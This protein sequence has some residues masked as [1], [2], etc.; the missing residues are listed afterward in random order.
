MAMLIEAY[1]AEG[2]IALGDRYSFSYL[3]DLIGQ[4]AEMRKSDEDRE[5]EVLDEKEQ[6]FFEKNK[7][8]TIKISDDEGETQKIPV[9]M[10]AVSADD[11]FGDDN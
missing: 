5:Q 9:S 10:F 6:D 2:A 3:K 4:T 11:L 1:G 7:H 8:Q